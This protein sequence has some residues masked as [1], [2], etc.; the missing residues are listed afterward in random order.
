MTIQA[1]TVFDVATMQVGR[2]WHW[3]K[4]GFLQWLWP[5]AGIFF[6]GVGIY[7]VQ[8]PASRATGGAAIGCG[9][10]CLMRKWLLGIQSRRAVQ[11]SP[12]YRKTFNWTFS[13]QELQGE[14]EQSSFK[15][16]WNQFA[17]TVSTPNGLLLYPVKNIYYWI[18]RNG[19]S[20][21]LDYEAAK[22]LIAACPKYR[23]LT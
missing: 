10:W 8:Q 15:T 23:E 5:I 2:E 20:S 19:F 17:E 18:P 4:F 6:I 22:R 3:R 14:G 1:K 12:Q 21:D 13:E 16:A 11:K 7:L 9:V